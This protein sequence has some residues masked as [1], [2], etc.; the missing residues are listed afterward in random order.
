M[1]KLNN[2]GITTIEVLLCFILV[3]IITIS[4]Y[5]TISTFNQKRLVESYKS[6]IYTYKN[7]LT[8]EIQ[9]DFIK[10]GLTHALYTKNVSGNTTTYTIECELKDGTARKLEIVQTLAYSSYHL[11]GSK[12]DN[13][14]F[15]IRYGTPT[16]MID[17]ALPDL[18]ESKND[19]GHT[20]KDLSINNVLISIDDE[21]VLSI[22]VGF[23]HPELTTRYAIN[24]IAPINYISS[25]SEDSS[26]FDVVKVDSS[27]Y[28]TFNY[29]GNVQTFTV[30]TA[31]KYKLEVWGAQGGGYTTNQELSSHAGLGGYSTGVVQLNKGDVLYVVVGGK[32][33]FGTGSLSGGYNGGGSNGGGSANASGSGGGATH[34]ALASGTLK[35]LSSNKSAVLI[36]AGGGGGADNGGGSS[37]IGTG[38][39]GSGG[40]GG[41]EIGGA[42]S[43]DGVVCNNSLHAATSGVSASGC[44][45]GG[46]QTTGYAFGQG[47]SIS[48]YTTDTGGGGGGWYGGYITGHYNG[49][50]GGGSGYLNTTVLSSAVMYCYNCK[51]GTY[52]KSTTAT[53]ET[54]TPK[55]AKIGNGAARI[56]YYG[57]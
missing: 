22:Y 33:N 39:D 35:S 37:K 49:G 19:Y 10:V 57:T 26:D 16:D 52:T 9:D 53:S 5:G 36:V 43:I 55:S 56:S 44:G 2:H 18:G 38:D 31:G 13:D 27:L 48:G 40:S 6:K 3:S 41:G 14:Y 17:Y 1:K 12:S 54:T 24:I 47:E 42:A 28:Q 34:I 8:K 46:T 32:G 50:A 23:Y 21:N 4:M 29:T 25:A 51:T 30:K 7:L 15:M 20:V 45:M 11:G